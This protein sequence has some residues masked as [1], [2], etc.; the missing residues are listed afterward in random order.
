MLFHH[1]EN[2][3]SQPGL[4]FSGSPNMGQFTIP[5]GG[6]PNLYVSSGCDGAPLMISY[7]DDYINYLLLWPLSVLGAIA[8]QDLFVE[9]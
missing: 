4:G 7:I 5:P 8:T 6:F 3:L 1:H 9:S 2:Q